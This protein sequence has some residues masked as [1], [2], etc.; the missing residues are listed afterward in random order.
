MSISLGHNFNG[1]RRIEGE[2]SILNI[3]LVYICMVL[4]FVVNIYDIMRILSLKFN[5]FTLFPK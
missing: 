3:F 4:I 2:I 1:V 5:S